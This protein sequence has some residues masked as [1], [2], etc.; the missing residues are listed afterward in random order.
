MRRLIQ[1]VIPCVLL[2]GC[3]GPSDGVE[4]PVD[5]IY[6]PVGLALDGQGAAHDHLYVV[7]SDFD[8]Q[9]NGGAVQSYDLKKLSE[10]YLPRL[11]HKGDANEIDGLCPAENNGSDEP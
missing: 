8:L 4:V 3:F 7:S 1:L 5:Q 9:Y 11:C 6:F 10:Q 2:S